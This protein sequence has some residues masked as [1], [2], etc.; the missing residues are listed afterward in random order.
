MTCP[1]P[2]CHPPL[3]NDDITREALR[4][5]L[6]YTEEIVER[7]DICPWA[8]H[9]RVAGEW[10]RYVLLQR[11][12]DLGPPLEAIRRVQEDPRRLAVAILIFPC[13]DMTQHRFDEF[14]AAFRKADQ[15]RSDGNPMFVSASF[16]PDYPLSE[17][18]P[19][20]LVPFFRRSPDPSIQL[21]RLSILE[22]ARGGAHGSFMFD[23]SPAAYAELARR[24]D[25]PSVT[26][27]I[28]VE[29]AARL[30]AETPEQLEAIYRDIFA[31][32]D[33]TYAALKT[34]AR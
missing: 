5:H 7:F 11:D 3:V 1:S 28:T 6:R 17:R 34:P 16:H 21:V 20:S 23:F 12:G 24:R 31:D 14:V 30:R 32:R 13:I 27:R 2:T 29:N 25:H 33:R 19:A 22:E 4:L 18:S 10:D 9:A 26:D 8:H 15:D